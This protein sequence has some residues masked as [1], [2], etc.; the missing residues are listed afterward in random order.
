MRSCRALKVPD[1]SWNSSKGWTLRRLFDH[2]LRQ[3]RL[4]LLSP[5]LLVSLLAG[6]APGADCNFNE[7]TDTED[8]RR[9]GSSDCNEN[10]I[11]DECEFVPISF[12]TPGDAVPLDRPPSVVATGDFDGDG[13]VDVVLGIKARAASPASILILAGDG[14]A[15]LP[16]RPSTIQTSS[17]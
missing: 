6:R 9:G 5:L 10:S 12:G 13:K 3:P 2:P 11:P 15:K 4:G 14:N 7:I 8:I 1:D 16:P 17:W